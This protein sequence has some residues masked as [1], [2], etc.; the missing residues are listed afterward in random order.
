MA[1]KFYFYQEGLTSTNFDLIEIEL[2]CPNCNRKIPSEEHRRRHG[3]KWCV[4]KKNTKY[5]NGK[6]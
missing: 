3:C 6:Y 1:S 5:C 4:P 2:L